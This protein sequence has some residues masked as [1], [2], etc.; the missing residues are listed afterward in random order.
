MKN[1]KHM[2]LPG[3]IFIFLMGCSQKEVSINQIVETACGQCQFNM[4]QQAGCDLA[5]RIDSAYYFVEGS[6]IDD[7]G[8]AHSDAGLCNSIQKAEVKGTIKDGKFYSELFTLLNKNTR[9][10]KE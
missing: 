2:I 1:I 6:K 8:D 4:D 7:H 3:T 9:E 5:I 10:D